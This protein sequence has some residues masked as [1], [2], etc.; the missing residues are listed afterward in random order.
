VRN[1]AVAAALSVAQSKDRGS[2]R[3]S[4][5]VKKSR[6]NRLDSN[7]FTASLGTLPASYGTAVAV[8]QIRV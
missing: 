2:G 1:A 6:Q 7:F 4:E 3:S 8:P 5:A